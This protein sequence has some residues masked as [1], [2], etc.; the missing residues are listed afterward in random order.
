MTDPPRIPGQAADRQAALDRAEAWGTDLSVLRSN[1]RLAPT[2]RLARHQRALDLVASLRSTPPRPSV[3]PS[4]LDR[5]TEAGAEV[6]VVGGVAAV[7]HGASYVTAD[8]GVCYAT[9]EANR[10]RL[11]S[12]LRPLDPYPRDV[13]PGLPFIWDERALCDT[14]FLT[15]ETTGGLLDLVPDVPGV[16]A[17][18][19]VR[20]RSDRVEVGGGAVRVLSLDALI[21]A[22]RA[23]DRPK[24]RALLVELEALQ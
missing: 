21:D 12:A 18:P 14:P 4:L 7:L 15:L 24:D 11:V 23:M 20:E 8:L 22:K 13:A 10:R 9:T 3:S 17:Y 16:G 5:L 6:V 19:A 1:L 2:E